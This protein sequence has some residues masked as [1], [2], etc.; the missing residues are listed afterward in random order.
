MHLRLRI[1]VVPLGDLDLV[2]GPHKKSTECFAATIT[3]RS[4]AGAERERKVG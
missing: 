1:H 4:V 2:Y 3:A